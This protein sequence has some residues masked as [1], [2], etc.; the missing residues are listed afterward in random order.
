MKLLLMPPFHKSNPGNKTLPLMIYLERRNQT[1][2]L[3]ATTMDELL[4]QAMDLAKGVPDFSLPDNQPTPD[5]IP[6]LPLSAQGQNNN[7]DELVIDLFNEA[8][9]E[10]VTPT[11]S[12]TP[13]PG[14]PPT[15]STA[16]NEPLAASVPEGTLGDV[17]SQAFGPSQDSSAGTEDQLPVAP[18]E[19][20]SAAVPPTENQPPSTVSGVES[21]S[22]LD[23]L[24]QNILDIKKAF[25]R[26]PSDGTSKFVAKDTKVEGKTKAPAQ[27]GKIKATPKVRQTTQPSTL[28]IRVPLDRLE[29]MNDVVGELAINRNSLALQNE[30]LQTKVKELLN[31]FVNFQ[32]IASQLQDISDQLIINPDRMG[33][34]NGNGANNQPSAPSISDRKTNYGGLDAEFDSLEMDSYNILSTKM[35]SVLEELMLLEESVDD[36]TLFARQSNTTI[37]S[38]KQMLDRLRDELMWSRMLPLGDILK[39]FP[40]VLRDLSNRYDKPAELKLSGTGV[41]VDKAVLEKLYDPLLHLLRNAFDHGLEDGQ[42]RVAAGKLKKGNIEIRAFHQGS[43]TL[44]E[45]KDDG[46]GINY[47]RLAQKVVERGL[48]RQEQLSSITPEELVNFIFEPGFSTAEKVSDLSGRGVGLDVVR[49]QLETLKGSVSV[50]SIENK[51]TTFTMKLPLTLSITKILVFAIGTTALGIASDGIEEIIIPRPDRIKT[52]A[53]QKF[54]TW[55]DQIVPIHSVESML[56][57]NCALPE[58]SSI[59]QIAAVSTPVGWELPVLI[60]KREDQVFALEVERLVTEQELVI[61]PFDPAIAPPSYM[62]GCTILGDG[63]LIPV[64]EGVT[65]LEQALGANFEPKVKLSRSTTDQATPT[66]PQAAPKAGQIPTVLVVDDSAALRKTLAFTLQKA[67]YRVV[68]AKDGKEALEKLHQTAH[69][70]MVICDVEMPNMNGFE[71]LGQKR[72]DKTIKTIPVAMLTSRSNDKHRRLATQLGATAYFSKP[73]VEQQF[74]GSI[75]EIIAKHSPTKAKAQI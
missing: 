56:Q 31:R 52:S 61:K 69:V 35:Q 59:D 28:S 1:L 11:P 70:E 8:F 49:S 5:T 72:K 65:L 50:S 13:L 71:F 7:N 45:I 40:R 14:Q 75:Q 43:Q 53:G 47:D 62:Y 6:N 26:L 15:T 42:T 18:A 66:Q 51:G 24:E 46:G 23:P 41:L 74:L 32:E 25:D 4:A 44:I 38:Q 3:A 39:R 36:V 48:L 63:T 27:K 67:G 22:S 30:Q 58:S 57:Y 21:S 33:P 68:Q 64:I 9:A 12:P 54:L 73:Y 19:I 17:L 37:E 55:R 34:S 10:E 60:L 2:R 29:K 16:S 20:T